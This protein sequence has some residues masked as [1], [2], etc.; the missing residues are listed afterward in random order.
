[1][2]EEGPPLLYYGLK[3]KSS[4]DRIHFT[5][6]PGY[7]YQ[8][9]E[10]DHGTAGI[11]EFFVDS[12][13][14]VVLLYIGDLL[15]INNIRRAYSTDNGWTFS[16][17]KENVLGD[18]HDGK[19]GSFIDHKVVTL[20]NGKK[21]LYTIR[22]GNIYSFISNDDGKTFVQETGVRLSP[23]DYPYPEFEII[24]FGDPVFIELQDGRWRLYTTA[25]LRGYAPGDIQKEMIVSA[26]T[27]NQQLIQT[28]DQS[29]QDAN[30]Q[31]Q[32]IP[33]CPENISGILTFPIVASEAIDHMVPLGHIN[34]GN[35]HVKPISHI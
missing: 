26:T 25:F 10:N 34:P 9:P 23:S 15:G 16:F 35:K 17:E 18:A 13:G 5:E 22:Q 33:G 12:S 7:R 1:M 21:R 28:Q 32:D 20:K 6:D 30:S 4:K 31:T 29:W 8:L 27:E 14:G 3:S 19:P 2:N 24:G 11:H